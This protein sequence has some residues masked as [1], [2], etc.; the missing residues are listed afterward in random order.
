MAGRRQC[1]HRPTITPSKTCSA[2]LY[3]RIKRKVGRSLE[4]AHCKRNL[5]L[6]RKQ[7]PYKLSGTQSSLSSLKRVSR[8]L[9]RQNSSCSNR[10]HHSGVMHQHGGRHEGGPTLCPTVENLDLVYQK[11]SNSLSLT[12]PRPAKRG[13]RRAIQARPDYSNRVV[14]PSRGFSNNM[15]Q[16]APTPN[17]SFCHEVQQQVASVCVT[18]A[19]PSGHSSGYTQSAM[20]GSGCI[21]LPTSSH[22]GQSGGEVA[23]L[24]MQDDHSAQPVNTALQSD[25]LMKSDKSKP[26]CMVPRAGFLWGSGS[27]N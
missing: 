9:C 5:V 18:G 10:Q 14:S 3:R 24:P 12:H 4:W 16:V 22:I 26:P 2:N 6:P 20:G 25:P 23:G 7:A 11:T 21:C 15:Q 8:F 17:R 1:T 13:S 27:K 19:G